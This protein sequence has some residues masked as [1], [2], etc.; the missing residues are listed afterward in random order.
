MNH[1]P[2][3]NLFGHVDAAKFS[4]GVNLPSAAPLEKMEK[5]SFKDVMGDLV[6]SVNNEIDKPDAL[7]ADLM[8][9]KPNVDV[10]DVM[11]AMAKAELGV[12]VAAQVTTKIINAYDRVS[13]IQI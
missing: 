13:Q 2:K 3:L 1:V 10:H 5:T 6:Q 4:D 9:G 7:L 8:S 11:T 12:S